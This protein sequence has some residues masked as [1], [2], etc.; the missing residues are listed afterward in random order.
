MPIVNAI[1]V[2][3]NLIQHFYFLEV[4]NSLIEYQM[5]IDSLPTIL[6]ERI[7]SGHVY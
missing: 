6:F 3:N 1:M 7:K 4:L 5:K 2:S